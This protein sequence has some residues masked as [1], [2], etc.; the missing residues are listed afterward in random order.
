MTLTLNYVVLS[1]GNGMS[2]RFLGDDATQ[3][4][5]DWL[6][7]P[8]AVKASTPIQHFQKSTSRANR[9]LL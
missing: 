5:P 4:T 8:H 9:L 2:R 6:S 3:S 7:D 1:L